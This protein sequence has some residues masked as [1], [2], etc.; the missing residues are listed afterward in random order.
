MAWYRASASAFSV[1]L[2]RCPGHFA[3]GQLRTLQRQIVVWRAKTV[4]AFD[5]GWTD[6]VER[7]AVQSLPRPLRVAVQLGQPAEYTA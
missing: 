1:R 7:V 4:L 2:E 3:N 6:D 5:D